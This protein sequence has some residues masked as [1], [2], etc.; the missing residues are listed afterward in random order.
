MRRRLFI[1]SNS[2][3]GVD[4][5]ARMTSGDE[6]VELVVEMVMVIFR[7]CGGIRV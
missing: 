7:I 4:D 2:K 3:V 5:D 6:I 1:S